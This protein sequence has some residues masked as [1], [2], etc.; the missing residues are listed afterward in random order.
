MARGRASCPPAADEIRGDQL[1]DR[2]G[3]RPDDLAI[4]HRP[5]RRGLE[6]PLTNSAV[7][8]ANPGGR[9]SEGQETLGA[10]MGEETAPRQVRL[11]GDM[12]NRAPPET[13][14]HVGAFDEAE[15]SQ[16]TRHIFPEERLAWL[17]LGKR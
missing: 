17:H 4:N 11:D 3:A 6:R 9:V 10:A 7:H 15:L 1:E 14:F 12:R 5:R 8:A 2:Q 13:H 16:A